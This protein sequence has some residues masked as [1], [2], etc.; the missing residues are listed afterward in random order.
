MISGLHS[1]NQ[2][3]LVRTT[4]PDWLAVVGLRL[5]ADPKKPFWSWEAALESFQLHPLLITNSK[6]RECDSY[7]SQS[8]SKIFVYRRLSP[9]TRYDIVRCKAS[10]G[11][12]VFCSSF[13]MYLICIM[14]DRASSATTTQD[15]QKF[16]ADTFAPL[17]SGAYRVPHVHAAAP[18]STT[19]CR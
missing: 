19:C 8:L 12:P 18:L 7:W 17:N 6:P 4:R 14:Y 10:S 13:V 16:L 9:I 2:Q 15:V 5:P 3:M 1:F 11:M